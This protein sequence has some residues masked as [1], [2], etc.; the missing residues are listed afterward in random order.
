MIEPLEPRQHLTASKPAADG[1]YHLKT[2]T[3]WSTL[4]GRIKSTS[5]I[6]VEVTQVIDRDFDGHNATF[7]AGNALQ[8]KDADDPEPQHSMFDLRTKDYMTFS[9]ARI[10]SRPRDGYLADGIYVK[11]GT[12]TV[13]KVNWLHVGEDALTVKTPSSGFPTPYVS[14]RGG[15]ATGYTDKC[16][17]INT[18]CTFIVRDGFVGRAGSNSGK[19]ARTDGGQKSIEG[20]IRVYGG[21]TFY[22]GAYGVATSSPNVSIDVRGATFVGLTK[23]TV[24]LPDPSVTA[25]VKKDDDDTIV[26]I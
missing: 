21:A 11:G 10:N 25:K 13:R 12:V 17:Q 23:G 4:P 5:T 7:L 24:G 15:S 6:V 14:V 18:K 8:V 26:K 9:N 22:G 20:T 16:F 3:D 2:A 1:R 19:G